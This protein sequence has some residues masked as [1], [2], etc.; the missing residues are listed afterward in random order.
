MNAANDLDVFS[1]I[2]VA[3]MQQAATNPDVRTVVQWKQSTKTSAL[4]TFNGTRRYLVQH[5]TGNAIVSKLVQDM[6]TGVDMGIAKSVDDFVRWGKANYPADHYVLVM[7]D[8][9]NGWLPNY[10]GAVLPPLPNAISYD[11]QTGHS[12]QSW[13]LNQAL[14]GQHLDI[15]A[16]D[17]SLMQ[18][19]E[20]VYQIKDSVDYIVGSEESPPGAGYPYQTALATFAANPDDTPKNLAKSFVDAMV[21]EPTYASSKIEQSVIDT[22]QLANVASAAANLRSALVANV[23]TVGAIMPQV[24]TNTQAY[25]LT[26]TRYFFDSVDL[27]NQIQALSSNSTVNTACQAYATAVQ[28]AVVWEGH[29]S[30]SSGSHGLAIDFSPSSYYKLVNS[31]YAKLTWNTATSWGNWLTIAP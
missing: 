3:Q 13:Q 11:G 1:P 5:G 30:H 9:G 16:F 8:H 22:S 27:C 31:E 25:L 10:K 14:A 4:S 2:N 28:S 19:V 24:R 18:M 21:N 17:A 7:W 26:S 20:V 23:G 15:L 29:N 12:I 6:G